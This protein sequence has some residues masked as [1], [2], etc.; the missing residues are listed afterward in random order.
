VG[1]RID[2]DRVFPDQAEEESSLLMQADAA[3]GEAEASE[4]GIYLFPEDRRVESAQQLLV[5]GVR[6][7]TR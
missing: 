4:E 7:S 5:C 3:M 2:R 6:F 1:A